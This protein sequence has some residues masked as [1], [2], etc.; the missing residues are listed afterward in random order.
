MPKRYC[1]NCSRNLLQESYSSNQWR[2]G[3]GA[4]RCHQCVHGT[5]CSNNNKA[6]P[7]TGRYNRST[8]A[9]FTYYALNHPFAEGSFRHVAKG[10][11]TTGER[12]GEPAVCKW[13]KKG[14][15]YE[16]EF[17]SKDI[18]AVDKALHIVDNWNK[19]SF[20][21]KT[22]RLNIPE[23]WVFEDGGK[24]GRSKVLQEPFIENYKKFNSNSGWMKDDVPWSRVMQALS[25]YS[26]HATGGQLVICDLQGGIYKDGAVLTDPVILSR[27][28]TYGVTDL[29]PMGISTFFSRHE[30]NEFCRSFWHRPKDQN[31]YYEKKQ[32]TS[33]ESAMDRLSLVSGRHTMSKQF[34]MQPIY[35]SSDSDY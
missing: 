33:M 16:E 10:V 29:G 34:H 17:F 8:R 12:Q 25:H 30:C 23:V 21:G 2:K 22:I 31:A 13:F 4:S 3:V 19:S 5:S 28:R 9:E 14:F 35:E 26:Y 1:A 11:Y 18:K 24:F 6:A 7:L 20:I 32:G 27:S 15:V